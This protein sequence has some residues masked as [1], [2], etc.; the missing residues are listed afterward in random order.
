[1]QVNYQR[2]MPVMLESRPPIGPDLTIMPGKTFESF[3]TFELIYD[4]TD[5][6]RKALALRRMY[7]TIAP[8]VTENP[9]LMHVRN[10][11]SNSIRKAVDQCAEVGFEMVILTFWSG[12]DMEKLDP[13]YIARIKADVDYAHSKGIE[14]GGYSLL[15]SRSINDEND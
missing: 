5:R 2:K 1:S 3:R 6:E 8:W 9:I 7:R 11:D 14:L 4:S 15:A 10:S 12:F 13:G